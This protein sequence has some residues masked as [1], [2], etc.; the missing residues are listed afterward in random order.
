MRARGSKETGRCA[1]EN[2]FSG[3]QLCEDFA[4]RNEGIRICGQGGAKRPARAPAEFAYAC[5]QS[6]WNRFSYA[7]PGAS[8]SE[9]AARGP[10][11]SPVLGALLSA[12]REVT[13]DDSRSISIGGGTYAKAMPNM[14]AFGPNFPWR[15][16]REHMEDEYILV[17]D[18][19][20]LKEI[21]ER[22]LVYLLDSSDSSSS[23]SRIDSAFA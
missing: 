11:D 5:P 2:A 17:E 18:F 14:V 12:Y 20:K 16:N 19:L 21:Y 23:S 6:Q 10:S 13:G 15:E 22:A 1:G 8:K 4:P 3:R 7:N 9:K